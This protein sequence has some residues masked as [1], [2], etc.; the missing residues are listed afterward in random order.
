MFG[1]K[2]PG[3][4]KGRYSGGLSIYAKHY[5]KDKLEIIEEN[6]NCLLW[7]NLSAEQ[8][9]FNENV[10][11]C[12]VYIP[13]S[14][15]RIFRT[16][17]FNYRDEIEKDIE[18]YSNLGKVFITGDMKGRISNLSYVL[19]FDKYLENDDLFIDI[20]QIPPRSNKDSIL[21]S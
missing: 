18:L 8:F 11:I 19:D 2:A 5:L 6:S 3:S 20:S 1:T 10:Y 7:L 4:S 12:C 17:D 14:D 16:A 15:S 9:S 13:P 21:D